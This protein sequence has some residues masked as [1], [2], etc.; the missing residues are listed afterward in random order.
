[1]EASSKPCFCAIA[2]AMS[3]SSLRYTRS[4]FVCVSRSVTRATRCSTPVWLWWRASWARIR[5][6][7]PPSAMIVPMLWKMLGAPLMTLSL[8]FPKRSMIITWKRSGFISGS[9]RT[10]TTT[11]PPRS[12]I[13]LTFELCSEMTSRSIVV[14]SHAFLAQSSTASSPPRNV[15][16]LAVATTVCPSSAMAQHSGVVTPCM[17]PSIVVSSKVSVLSGAR[18][19]TIVSLKH[20][21]IVCICWPLWRRISA[22]C[23]VPDADRTLWRRT[24][25]V[26]SCSRSPRANRISPLFEFR[27]TTMALRSSVTSKDTTGLASVVLASGAWGV[28]VPPGAA[29][30][31]SLSTRD[32]L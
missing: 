9:G 10:T 12:H 6:S 21:V 11:R 29:L 1:M 4:S 20:A 24:F 28:W 14:G 30:P 3:Y 15:R 22:H 25:T 26:R 5:R 16:P 31:T 23:S 7:L 17:M 8:N 13:T 27:H 32:V 18:T 2:T 19:S